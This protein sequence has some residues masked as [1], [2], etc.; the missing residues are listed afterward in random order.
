MKGSLK[1]KD[2]NT[3]WR[4]M[5]LGLLLCYSCLAG[6]Q[7]SE[8][9]SANQFQFTTDFLGWNATVTEPI[10]LRHFH[11]NQHIEFHTNGQE[12]MRVN[13]SGNVCIGTTIENAA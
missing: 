2:I 4:F 10:M 3:L 6:S 13:A 11:P 5:L 7:A 1:F 9:N 12:R 8:I